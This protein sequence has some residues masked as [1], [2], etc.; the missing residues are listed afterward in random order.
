MHDKS[1]LLLSLTQL[2]PS[3][4]I[5]SIVQWFFT[6]LNKVVFNFYQNPV[7][8]P[9]GG[10]L[11]LFC[12]S[13]GFSP[14]TPT[15]SSPAGV[16]ILWVVVVSSPCFSNSSANLLTPGWSALL[17][18]APVSALLFCLVVSA[19]AS[20]LVENISLQAP[21]GGLALK[22]DVVKNNDWVNKTWVSSVQLGKALSLVCNLL[23]WMGQ[24]RVS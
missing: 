4:L 11:P 12:L 19:P 1:K 23:F 20:A 8:S 3:L 16:L 5:S 9:P 6:N 21:P 22:A 10:T 17:L 2:S 13:S 15:L 18:W 7:L 24:G 14:G